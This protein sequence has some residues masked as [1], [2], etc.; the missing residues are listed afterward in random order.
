MLR[1]FTLLEL[2]VVLVII[3]V[4]SSIGIAHF[5]PMREQILAKEAVVHLKFIQAAERTVQLER[6]DYV[7]CTDTANCNSELGLDLP[8]SNWDYAVG[9]SP[10][11]DTTFDATADRLTGGWPNCIYNIDGTM[12]NTENNGNCVYTE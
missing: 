2:I 11:G 4:L 7:A 5:G 3:G 1:G 9:Y 12:T 8:S 6:G 10:P